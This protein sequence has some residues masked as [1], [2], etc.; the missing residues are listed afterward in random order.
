MDTLDPPMIP[1]RLDGFDAVV[2]GAGPGGAAAAYRLAT[3]GRRVLLVDRREFPRDK[4]CGDGLTRSAVRLLA[5]LGVLDELTG[6]QRVGGVRIRMRGRGGRDFHYEDPDGTGYGMVVPRLELDAVLCRR[7]VR[8]GAVLWTGARA[9]RLLGGAA[10]VHGVQVEYAGRRFSLRTPAVVAADGA[11]SRLAHQAGLRSPDREWTGFAARGYFTHIADLDELLEIH[12][13]LADVTDRRVLPSYGWVFPVGDGTANVGVG[14]F[15]PAHREN[16]RLLY[17]RFVTELMATDHRFRAA[18]PTGPMTGAPLRLD[19][20][21]SRCGVPGLLLV[22]DAAGLVSPFTGE[23]ISFALES[24]L[25]AADRIDTA[26]RRAETGP[27]DPAPYARQLAARQSGYFETGRYSVRRYLLAWRVLDATF[28]DDRPLFALCRRLALFP[29]GARAGVLLDPLPQPAPELARDL[30]RDLM[31]VGE[32]LAGCVREDWPMFVRLGGVDEDLSTLSLRPA[33]LLLVAAAVGGREHPLR[34][35][36]AAAVDLGLLAGLA[37]DSAREE[38][39]STGP[40]PTPWGN[41]FAVLVA[42]FLLA[43]AYEFAAQGGGPVVAEFAEALTVA[44][45]GR[46]QELRDDPSSGGGAGGAVLVGRAA[47]AFE[48]PCRLG[49]RLGGARVPVVNAL[50]TYGR[51]V[52]AAYALGEQLREL[53]GASR[54]GGSTQ[55]G[56]VA[57]D[58]PR[59]AG[60]LGLIAEHAQRAREALRI[61]PAGPARELLA[62]LATPGLPG[63][64]DPDGR[65]MSV[66]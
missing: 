48:L 53:A 1:D 34:H 54:W 16:V 5:E 43:R 26:R 52:G 29:D 7:A 62:R 66:T 49:G 36:L 50:A 23:G 46:A 32:L 9:T 28:D 60:L 58:D 41:R 30:R 8:A 61:V 15:D 4:C 45:E 65:V 55:P 59:V 35:A 44:C 21:P 14:L 3:L 22:G 57:P 63:T 38:P 18:R 33:V 40:R 12:L 56:A 24:G 13:P 37:V 2:V 25:L 47:I 10:G 19:F 11:S 39:R 20:D 17:E 6:A 31:A 64:V 42:D 27:V 51:E